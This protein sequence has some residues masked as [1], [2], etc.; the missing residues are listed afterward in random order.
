MR[1]FVSLDVSDKKIIE[2]IQ[3]FQKDFKIDATPTKI[4]NLHFTIQFLGEKNEQ[5]V[6]RIIEEL[7]KIKFESFRINF[8]GVG[9]FPN[10]NNPRIVWIGLEKGIEE[11]LNLVRK[12]HRRLTEIGYESDKKFKAHVTIFRIKRKIGSIEHKIEMNRTC[13]F[14]EQIVSEFKLKKSELTKTGPI[15]SDLVVV[16]ARK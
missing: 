11:M 2:N 9:T 4:E 8:N 3:K 6:M 12:I 7:K 1:I 15:Y 14:G 16:K 10:S 5:E 13:N